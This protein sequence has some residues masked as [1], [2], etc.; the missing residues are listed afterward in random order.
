MKATVV[1]LRYRTK[2]LMRAVE[3]REPVFIYYRGKLKAKLVPADEPST[4]FPSVAEHPLFGYCK[5]DKEPVE[6]KVRRLRERKF[7]L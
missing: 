6:E 4:K 5:D 3:R 7:D 2:D 1:D